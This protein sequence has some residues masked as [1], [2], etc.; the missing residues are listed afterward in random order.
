M[1]RVP[2]S[3]LLACV[4]APLVWGCDET[5]GVPDPFGSPPTIAAFSLTPEE[6]N[7]TSTGQTVTLEPVLTV[8]VTGGE[9]QVTVRAFI[10]DL[11]GDDLIAE[12]EASGGAG[13]F[14]LRP[15]FEIPRGA[16]G[17]YPIT[18]TTEDASGRIGDRATAVLV[19][20]S[21]ALGGPTVTATSSSPSPVA[22]PTSG[23]RTVTLM[24][25]I[26]DPDGIPNVA[27]VELRQRTGD[28]LFRFN[29][30]GTGGDG[31]AGDGR[32]ALALAINS[33]TPTGTYAFDV[34][35]TDRHGLASI[36]TEITFTVQ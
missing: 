19:F 17:R 13:R 9:G 23:S 1:P 30:D 15:S 11:L 18:I 14:E 36:P 32:F 27:Y 6:V 28:V 20:L 12:A 33:A 22:R 8:D 24:A 35:A 21:E 31:T 7:D 10:R 34:V 5:P 3:L 16:V 25:D 2:R 29:D 4:L 26:Q